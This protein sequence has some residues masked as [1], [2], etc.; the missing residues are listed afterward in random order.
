[1]RRGY[2]EHV[3]IVRIAA[4]AEEMGAAGV[5]PDLFHDRMEMI[6]TRMRQYASEMLEAARINFTLEMDESCQHVSLPIE[7]RKDFYLVFKEAI[8]NMAKYAAAKNATIR[9]NYVHRVLE[10][11][12]SDDGIGFNPDHVYSG[13]GLKNMRARTSQLKGELVIHA[14]PGEGTHIELKIPVTP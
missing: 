7:K 12:I 1:M 14:K 11:L 13:N 5:E 9:L 10:L 2:P 3:T 6:L 4:L 8:N